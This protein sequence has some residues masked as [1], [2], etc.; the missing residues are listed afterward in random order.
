MATPVKYQSKILQW[1]KDAENSGKKYGVPSSLIL[2]II[3]HESGGVNNVVEPGKPGFGNG[4]GLGQFEPGTW[5]TLMP[6]NP[7][8]GNPQDN[9]DAIGKYLKQLHNQ[10]GSWELSTGAYYAGP[11]ALTSHGVTKHT[12]LKTALYKLNFIP[13]PK[14]GNTETIT[15]YMRA[16]M[17]NAGSMPGGTT[18]VSKAG[19]TTAQGILGISGA[20][21]N[22]P[23][24]IASAVLSPLERVGYLLAGLAMVIVGLYLLV[25][26]NTNVLSLV[27]NAAAGSGT[28][29]T[30]QG[31]EHGEEHG[32][33]TVAN[34][35]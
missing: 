31:E 11:G 23:G 4:G 14:S 1:Q 8:I 19:P 26:P 34:G 9:I 7:N 3:Q 15:Q 12:P 6:G 33:G 24:S 17:G 25:K 30:N 21:A 18:Q 10:F 13:S 29:D 28:H 27:S 32:E 20:I 16:V 2:S 22:L 5:A 35:D